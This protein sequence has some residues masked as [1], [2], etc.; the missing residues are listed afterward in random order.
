MNRKPILPGLAVWAALGLLAA[1][2]AAEEA[3]SVAGEKADALPTVDV[4]P[5]AEAA[6]AELTK[7]YLRLQGYIVSYHAGRKNGSLDCT[8]AF[9]EISGLLAIDLRVEHKGEKEETHQWNTLEDRFYTSS[10]D[11]LLVATGMNRE[12]ASLKRLQDVLRFN[13]GDAIPSQEFA[14]PFILLESK[15]YGTGITPAKPTWKKEAENATV[16]AADATSITFLTKEH[17]RLTI[18]RATGLLLR[19]S[20]E[21]SEEETIVLER[22]DLKLNPGREAVMAISKSWTVEGAKEMGILARMAPL[23]LMVFKGVIGAIEDGRGDFAKLERVLKDEEQSLRQFAAGCI[24]E[25][26]DSLYSAKFW[27]QAFDR[28]LLRKMW[29]KQDPEA[30][31]DD[32]EGLEKYI[33]SAGFR[34]EFRKVF[35]DGF[36]KHEEAA[37]RFTGEIFGSGVWD[38]LKT[39]GEAGKAAKGMLGKA[40]AKAYLEAVVE[41]KMVEQLGPRKGLD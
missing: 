35:V 6:M 29:L 31:E 37:G 5:T 40:L 23:R 24:S 12:M 19:Q 38:D 17:G 27:K 30:K 16:D 33:A 20:I 7:A 21:K 2:H 18:D 8:V 4:L 11:D 39:T 14:S 28:G 9:D 10:G 41:R 22:V 25:G 36:L 26:R 32:E 34:E 3:A 1:V 15:G 13:R